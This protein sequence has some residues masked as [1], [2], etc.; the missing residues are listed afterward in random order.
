MGNKI[1]RNKNLRQI[2]LFNL[3]LTVL[4]FIVLLNLKTGIDYFIMFSTPDSK[5]YLSVGNWIFES[6]PTDQTINNPVLYPIILKS[7]MSLFGVPGV[8]FVQFLFWLG[9][10]NFLFYTI[11]RITDKRFAYIGSAVFAVN[12]SFIALTLHALADVTVT[13]LIG[14]MINYMTKRLCDFKSPG[15]FYVV[16]LFFSLLSIIKPVFFPVLLFLLLVIFPLFYFKSFIKS[17]RKYLLIL[18]LLPVLFQIS[19]M[20]YKHNTFSISEKGTSTFKLFF[21]AQCYADLNNIAIEDAMNIVKKDPAGPHLNF[22]IENKYL[23]AKNFFNNIVFENITGKATFLDFPPGYR[24]KIFYYV[25]ELENRFFLILH[26]IFLAPCLYVLFRLWKL[27][28][29]V[30]GFYCFLLFLFYYLVLVTGIAFWQGDRYT[31]S[32]QPLWIVLYLFVIFSLYFHSRSSPG[33]EKK[34]INTGKNISR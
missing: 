2:I 25:M 21:Y 18:V 29:P 24:S 3:C 32:F 19:I 28:S 11:K 14:M 10:V 1:L 12:L 31:V 6:I 9:S 33:P 7:L 17:R 34:E 5:D 26:L 16:L 22:F 27:R 8:W 13:F 15:F 4:Y 20:L 30:L 23:V